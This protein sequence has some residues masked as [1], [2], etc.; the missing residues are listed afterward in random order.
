MFFVRVLEEQKAKV[1]KFD[2]GMEI[3]NCKIKYEIRD[4]N[5]FCSTKIIL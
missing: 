2:L 4:D 3:N 5:H 1:A